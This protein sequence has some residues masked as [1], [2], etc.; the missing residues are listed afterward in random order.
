MPTTAITAT[1]MSALYPPFSEEPVVGVGTA[2]VPVWVSGTLPVEVGVLGTG[3]D[4][5]PLGAGVAATTPGKGKLSGAAVVRMVVIGLAASSG[6]TRGIHVS[7]ALKLIAASVAASRR[8]VGAAEQSACSRGHS[9]E[10]GETLSVHVIAFGPCAVET[11]VKQPLAELKRTLLTTTD[12]FAN[13]SPS[14]T[15]EIGRKKL[16]SEDE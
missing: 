12:F 10:R 6:E 5:R 9:F 7:L 11:R 8:T 1:Q 14:C 4:A 3:A 2:T 15:C 16:S 13:G